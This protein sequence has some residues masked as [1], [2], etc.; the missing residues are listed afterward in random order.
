MYIHLTVATIDQGQ[1]NTTETIHKD[2]REEREIAFFPLKHLACWE[3][4]SS[5]QENCL[6]IDLV[7]LFLS[8]CISE[9]WSTF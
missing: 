5:I 3:I 6:I 2:Y 4:D 1:E 7:I 9:P 8:W